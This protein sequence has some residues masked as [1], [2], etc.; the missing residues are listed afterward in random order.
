[1]LAIVRSLTLIEHLPTLV[2]TQTAKK[3]ALVA[4][5]NIIRY[6]KRQDGLLGEQS[7][8]DVRHTATILLRRRMDF[9]WDILVRRRADERRQLRSVSAFSSAEFIASGGNTIGWQRT[10]LQ[11]VD[12]NNYRLR[13]GLRKLL[14]PNYLSNFANRPSFGAILRLR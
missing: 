4:K 9:R 2:H 14:R 11:C 8:A 5:L 1:M 12:Y 3:D 6:Q 10:T 7:A 13:R